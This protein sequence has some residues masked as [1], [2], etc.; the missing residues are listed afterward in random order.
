[1]ESRT[2]VDCPRSGAHLEC[3]S[4][5][6]EISKLTHG[7]TPSGSGSYPIGLMCRNKETGEEKK[8]WCDGFESG[9]VQYP[10]RIEACEDKH[11]GDSCTWY[12]DGDH[13]PQSGTCTY[14]KWGLTP[15]PLYCG[16]RDYRLQDEEEDAKK[17]L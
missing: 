12:T 5:Y 4:G 7:G 17:K 13:R 3:P 8:I 11:Y 10:T 6:K 14:D 15:G 2:G 1:M 16:G 9:N